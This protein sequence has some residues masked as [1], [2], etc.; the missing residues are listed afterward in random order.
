MILDF[1]SVSR[2]VPGLIEGMQWAETL[3][4]GHGRGAEKKEA[5][6]EYIT[7]LLREAVKISKSLPT[8]EK[9]VLLEA[10]V[11]DDKVKIIMGDLVDAI[12]AL[13][14]AVSIS[15]KVPEDPKVVN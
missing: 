14:N 1:G 15:V 6:V 8:P 4:P 13:A 5:V 10:A 11:Y 12:S 3:Y 2:L 7:S 9:V